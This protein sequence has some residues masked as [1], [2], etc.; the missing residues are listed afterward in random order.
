MPIQFRATREPVS[1]EALLSEGSSGEYEA[2]ARNRRSAETHSRNPSSSLSRRLF[3]GLKIRATNFIGGM[4][5]GRNC[6]ARTLL[7]AREAP[8]NA[9]RSYPLS[10]TTPTPTRFT[11]EPD[12]YRKKQSSR[13]LQSLGRELDRIYLILRRSS[14]SFTIRPL[15][16]VPSE[17]VVSR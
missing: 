7:S 15:I 6:V 1:T 16:T 4:F 14:T 10:S 17:S 5:Y 8:R 3:V 12:D 13:Q 11:P 2:S 9:P